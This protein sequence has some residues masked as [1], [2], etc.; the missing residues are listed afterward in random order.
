[1]YTLIDRPVITYGVLVFLKALAR[2]TNRKT[3]EKIQGLTTII[4]TGAIKHT[5]EVAVD[6]KWLNLQPLDPVI[7]ITAVKGGPQTTSNMDTSVLY[8][9]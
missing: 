1:M 2:E 8:R 5:S 3:I 6:V 7:K 9:Y 4:I